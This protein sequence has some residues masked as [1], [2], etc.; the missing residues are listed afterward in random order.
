MSAAPPDPPGFPDQRVGPLPRDAGSLA[1]PDPPIPGLVLAR[2]II[3]LADPGESCI[4]DFL[5]SRA[6]RL[7]RVHDAD[8]C[9]N[10]TLFATIADSVEDLAQIRVARARFLNDGNPVRIRILR[11]TVNDNTGLRLLDL[12]DDASATLLALHERGQSVGSTEWTRVRELLMHSAVAGLLV[13]DAGGKTTLLINL[14]SLRAL[15]DAGLVSIALYE[16][17]FEP[18]ELL[19]RP[20]GLMRLQRLNRHLGAYVR[21]VRKTHAHLSDLEDVLRKLVR[22]GIVI[23]V[24]AAAAIAR[25]VS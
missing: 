15:I 24:I 11:L 1:G 19:P 14:H 6:R 10:A 7:G 20:S 17:A 12:R 13:S 3:A 9:E 5:A 8:E 22:P 2:E 23:V 21:E 16:R 25:H 4:A 18:D